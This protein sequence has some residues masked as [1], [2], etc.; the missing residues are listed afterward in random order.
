MSTEK[1][2]E[3]VDIPEE[4]TAP[5]VKALIKPPKN[6]LRPVGRA[7]SDYQMIHNGDRLLLG[8]SG[9]KDSLSLLHVLRHLQTYAP[10]KF[11]L[12]AATVDPD[13]GSPDQRDPPDNSCTDHADSTNRQ[14]SALTTLRDINAA[15]LHKL[16]FGRVS[17]FTWRIH[18]T[19]FV[20]EM[21]RT[22]QPLRTAMHT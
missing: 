8:L 17:A 20:T 1:I 3:V 6:L 19:A 14:R 15:P 21:P 5:P 22:V 16:A 4:S 9:G 12:A 7:I 2:D 10:V 11:E 13:R 18:S